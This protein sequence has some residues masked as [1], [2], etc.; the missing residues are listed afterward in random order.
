VEFNVVLSV[1]FH[2]S[3]SGIDTRGVPVGSSRLSENSEFY[4]A[5]I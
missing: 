5:G 3:V 2:A 1:D 4:S